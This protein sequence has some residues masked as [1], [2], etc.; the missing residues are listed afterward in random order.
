MRQESQLISY[1]FINI[2]TYWL[3]GR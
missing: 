1:Y 2:I 3:R